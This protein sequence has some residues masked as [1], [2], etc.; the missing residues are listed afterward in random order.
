MN[1]VEHVPLHS[2]KQWI[3]MLKELLNKNNKLCL[4]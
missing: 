1:V 2:F 4:N 3:N